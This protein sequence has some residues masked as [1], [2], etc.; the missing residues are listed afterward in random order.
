MSGVSHSVIWG[1]SRFGFT[2]A[3]PPIPAVCVR[4]DEFASEAFR[5]THWYREEAD[6]V[7]YDDSPPERRRFRILAAREK[8]PMKG[9]L[10]YSEN[11]NNGLPDGHARSPKS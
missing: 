6:P 11:P 8:A 2:L 9:P 5:E 7:G 10:N 1:T 4:G 3:H